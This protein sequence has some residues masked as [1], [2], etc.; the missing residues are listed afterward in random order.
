MRTQVK[1]E[2]TRSDRQSPPPPCKPPFLD[3]EQ[4]FLLFQ[5][6]P[7]T[8]GMNSLHFFLCV[9]LPE[10]GSRGARGGVLRSVNIILT[11]ETTPFFSFSQCSMSCSLLSLQCLYGLKEVL[12][13][14]VCKP[15]TQEVL[16]F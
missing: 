9:F 2:Y 6:D 12:F 14:S 1:V 11:L 13:Y 4:D 10:G 7:S 15:E 3:T 5:L 8:S 16:R